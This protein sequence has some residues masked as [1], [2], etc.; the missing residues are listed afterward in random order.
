M[1]VVSNDSCTNDNEI[2]CDVVEEV[3][4][5]E[6]I[7]SMRLEPEIQIPPQPI[8]RHETIENVQPTPQL[9]TIVEH[10]HEV[11]FQKHNS[12][13]KKTSKSQRKKKV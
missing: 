3:T 10:V 5:Y 9:E 11:S 13:Q 4:E 1:E 12:T 2:K 7:E 6:I 8:D